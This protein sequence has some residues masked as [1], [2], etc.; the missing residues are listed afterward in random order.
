MGN[1]FEARQFWIF[2]LTSTTSVLVNFISRIVFDVWIGYTASIVCAYCIGILV[3]YFLARMYVFTGKELTFRASF[4]KFLMV[5]IIGMMQTL[6]ISIALS[7]YIL[8]GYVASSYVPEVAH[9]MALATLALTSYLLH[10]HFSF[11]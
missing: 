11:R 5:N 8:P 10:K 1:I 9:G 7:D 3:A 4:S 6:S 2:L